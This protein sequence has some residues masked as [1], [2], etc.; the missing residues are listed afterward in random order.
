MAQTV[1][2]LIQNLSNQAQ[3]YSDT[4]Y[5]YTSLAREEVTGAALTTDVQ[6]VPY[7][8]KP[9]DTSQLDTSV[10]GWLQNAPAAAIVA[11]L[12]A[13]LERYFN[14]FFP[15]ISE[16][17]NLWLAQLKRLVEEG[18]PLIED[19]AKKNLMAQTFDTAE[20]KRAAR[21]LRSGY[22]GKGLDLPAGVMVGAILDETDVRT[23]K[24]IDGAVTA[25]NQAQQKHLND[26]KTIISTAISTADARV[27]AVNAM[28]TLIQTAA[29]AYTSQIDAKVAVY[30]ARAAAAQAA[31]AYYEAES[32]LDEINT[33]LYKQ[34]V[35]FAVQRFEVDGKL[36]F[37]TENAQVSAAIAAAEQ[38]GTIAQ[39]S[40]SAL[41]TIVSASTAGFD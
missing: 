32:K 27:A 15:N 38:S 1:D 6:F 13:D 9:S 3:S 20:G 8:T 26:Y 40:Y 33:N 25:A 12:R 16:N 4:A 36:F 23:E 31:L 34:N 19:N 7:I 21:K 35:D 39:A 29:A 22:S 30:K 5:Y 37:R 14:E 24:L 11:N 28:S 18:T 10:P 17:Y 41:N 2:T